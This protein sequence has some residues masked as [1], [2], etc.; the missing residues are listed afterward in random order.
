MFLESATTFGA[1]IGASLVTI[2]PVSVI[3]IIFGAVLIHSVYQTVKKQIDRI[4]VEKSDRLARTLKL[5]SSYP[6]SDGIK[7]YGVCNVPAGFGLMWLAGLLSGLLGIGSGAVKMLAMDRAM[8]IPFKV[9]TTTSNFMIGV[10]AAAGAGIYLRNGLGVN[11]AWAACACRYA[12]CTR[13]LFSVFAFLLERDYPYV[14]I[15]LIVLSILI[16]SYAVL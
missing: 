16:S 3:Y 5:P 10:T 15:T 12:Y 1:I 9:S 11:A 2:T 14:V 4:D 13:V 8:K 7:S 6:T